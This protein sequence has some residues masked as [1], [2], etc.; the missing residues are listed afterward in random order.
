MI[1]GFL[2]MGGVIA[3]ADKAVAQSAAF[4]QRVLAS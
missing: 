3:A 2:T 4:L 1:H